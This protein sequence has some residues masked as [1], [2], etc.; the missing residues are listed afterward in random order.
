MLY[1]NSLRRHTLH[2]RRTANL[3]GGAWGSWCVAT[4][5]IDELTVADLPMMVVPMHNLGIPSTLM[6]WI[7]H[8]VRAGRTFT[9]TATG[10][11]GL[12]K[13]KRIAIDL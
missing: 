8:V 1:D 13:V 9:Y 4:T 11:Q 10:P 5:L 6:A 3:C 7:D 12:V 2:A